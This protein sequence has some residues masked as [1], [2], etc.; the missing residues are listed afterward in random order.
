M[1]VRLLK[2]AVMIASALALTIASPM[3]RA[4]QPTGLAKN[5]AT[6]ALDGKASASTAIQKMRKKEDKIQGISW[7]MDKSTPD[8]NNRNNVH[9]Y[10]GQKGTQVWLRLKLQYASDS[11]LFVKAYIVAADDKRFERRARFER[12]HHTTIWEWHDTTA[13]PSELEI[14]QAIIAAKEV[15]IR[16]VG[17]KYYDDRKVSPQ[18]KQ[19][20]KNV[21]EAYLALGGKL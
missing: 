11:W 14:V 6:K 12:D 2:P 16:Y 20:L 8:T 21:L 5:P 19:A 3:P 10:I 17:D 15:T 9:L 18:E 13:G 1:L 7:F 4:Q